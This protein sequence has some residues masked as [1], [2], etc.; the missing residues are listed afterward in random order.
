M[1][2][3]SQDYSHIFF[4]A[5]TQPR[6]YFTVDGPVGNDTRGLFEQTKDSITREISEQEESNWGRQQPSAPPPGL[7]PGAPSQGRDGFFRSVA[8]QVTAGLILAGVL[9]VI[10]AQHWHWHI[11]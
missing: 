1:T 4:C 9:A 10:A 6:V 11:W 3:V 8:A 2:S 7:Q 5:T